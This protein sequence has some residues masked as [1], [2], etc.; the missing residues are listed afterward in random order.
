V[1]DSDPQAGKLKARE[2]LDWDQARTCLEES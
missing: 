1:P 2:A